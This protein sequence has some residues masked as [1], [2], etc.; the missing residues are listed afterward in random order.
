MKICAYVPV[1]GKD[2]QWA[3][4]IGGTDGQPRH[5]STGKITLKKLKC[6]FEITKCR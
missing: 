6:D 3:P 1:G 2:V 4:I 5:Q